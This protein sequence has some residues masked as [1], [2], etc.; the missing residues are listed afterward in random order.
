VLLL[1]VLVVIGA[2]AMALAPARPDR[3]RRFGP[4]AGYAAWA[5]SGLLL[6][7]AFL[8]L[9]SIGL[10][11]LPFGVAAVVYSARRFRG[12][13]A[14]GSISGCGLALLGVGVANLGNHPCPH[15]PISTAPGQLT[16]TSCGG[17][18]ARPWLV[19]GAIVLAVGLALAAALWSRTRSRTSRSSQP[20]LG[21]PRWR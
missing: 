19:T 10:F 4:L 12:V 21:R 7:I 9:A 20:R 11:L 15:H 2:V 6:T 16:S 18:S 13:Q 14:V 17:A 8:A 5:I 3:R 1:T